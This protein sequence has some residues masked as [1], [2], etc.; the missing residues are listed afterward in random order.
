[1][2]IARRRLSEIARVEVALG[3]S[4]TTIY[5]KAHRNPNAPPAR[6]H[7]KARLEFDTLSHLYERFGPVPGCAVVRPI[8]FLPDYLAVVT[9]AGTGENLHRLVK[10]CAVVWGSRAA[11]ASAMAHCRGAGVWLRHFQTITD[12]GR[13]EPLP[14]GQWLEWIE[15]DVALCVK[16][17]LSTS[18][19]A[20]LVDSAR[21]RIAALADRRFAVVGQHPD[22][23]PDN[24]L[25]SPRGVTVLDFTSFQYG[26]P[27]SDVARFVASL[28]FLGK[29]PL[30]PRRR[31]RVLAAAFLGGIGEDT[32]A[33]RPA[34]VLSLI[35][36]MV[37]AARTVASWP[38]SPLLKGVVERQTMRFLAGWQRELAT[39]GDAFI[40]VIR[41]ADPSR[42][43]GW[44]ARRETTL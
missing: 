27:I 37:R 1:M 36:H 40:D 19:G 6:L 4:A 2:S 9:E 35:H 24:V 7:R 39:A 32:T 38:R 18:D 14:L 17:G 33:I 22:Y 28:D 20:G 12:Q 41:A 30:F 43:S 44:T 8:A 29:S 15:A 16:L 34:L 21:A 31:L 5:V 11:M 10:K 23:Q 13:Q 3:R 26:S 25:V 42:P